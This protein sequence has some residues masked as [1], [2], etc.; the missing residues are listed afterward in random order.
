[1]NDISYGTATEVGPG[2]HVNV[3]TPVLVL[4]M[5]TLTDMYHIHLHIYMRVH[6]RVHT[7]TLKVYTQNTYK[8]K[9]NSPGSA[10]NQFVVNFISLRMEE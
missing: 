10:L 4:H 6:S 8:A 5:C 7:Y 3:Y 2:F 1:M 9:K